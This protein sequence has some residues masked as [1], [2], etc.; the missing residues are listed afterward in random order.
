MFL[1]CV[2]YLLIAPWLLGVNASTNT[3][4]VDERIVGGQLTTISSVPYMVQ[5]WN[6]GVFSCGGALISRNSVLTAAHCVEDGRPSD[7]TVV[8]GATKLTETG[9]RSKVSKLLIPKGYDSYSLHMDVAM[10]KLT[11]PITKGSAKT[12]SFYN[13][14]LSAGMEVQVSG[15]GLTKENG[16]VS[17]QIRTVKFPIIKKSTCAKQYQY[18]LPL[19]STMFCAGTPGSK[20]SCSG[21]SGG[22]VIYK[23]LV[24]G[25]VS[26]G[27]GCA[28]KG[29]PGVYTDTKVSR[30]F[31]VGA[32]KKL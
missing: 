6:R 7:F 27:V 3:S 21:D 25:I 28:R 16:S 14:T 10:I 19:T 31:I 18:E 32:A 23:G 11:T 5:I 13:G 8:T 4:E 22:P 1:K 20:D 15:W 12:I 30:T 24:C 17:P 2:L 26:F 9:V 29:Y